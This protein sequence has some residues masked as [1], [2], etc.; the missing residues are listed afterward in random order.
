MQCR[1][2]GPQK[3]ER[4]PQQSSRVGFELHEPADIVEGVPEEKPG[5]LQGA[6]QIAEQGKVAPL[7]PGEEEGRATGLV[8]P[9]LNRPGLQTGIDLPIDPH[10]VSVSCQ[11]LHAL[12]QIAIPHGFLLNYRIGT[13]YCPPYGVVKCEH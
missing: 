8:D 12:A 9:A 10:K 3:A 13:G 11:I 6:E 2:Y 1:R 7:H 5:P 4:L